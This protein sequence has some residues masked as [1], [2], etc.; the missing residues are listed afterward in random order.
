MINSFPAP[1]Y[2]LGLVGGG[3]MVPPC[4]PISSAWAFALEGRASAVHEPNVHESASNEST[5]NLF[6]S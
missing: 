3:G 6:I 4:P 1:T 5:M 2:G